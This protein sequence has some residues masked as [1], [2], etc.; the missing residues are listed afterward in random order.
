MAPDQHIQRCEREDSPRPLR[1]EGKQGRI[2]SC[3]LL[4]TVPVRTNQ[5]HRLFPREPWNAGWGISGGD[6]LAA[7][8]LSHLLRS[9]LYVL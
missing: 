5:S 2:Y 8:E 4:A 9:R 7:D 3:S 1:G 6:L